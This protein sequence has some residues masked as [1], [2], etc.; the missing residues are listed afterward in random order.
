MLL[1]MTG[2]E[3]REY[4]AE[5]NEELLMADGFDEAL[6]GTVSGACRQA[7]ACYDYRKCVEILV[8]RD[9]MDEEEA[10]E[11]LDFNTLGAY[12]G[13]LTPLFVYDLRGDEVAD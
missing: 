5:N 9:G 7:V 10:E 4:L 3:I 2:A 6:I 13:E 12:V 1:S 8:K 11:F